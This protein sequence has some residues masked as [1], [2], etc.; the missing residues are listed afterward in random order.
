M[1]DAAVRRTA[2]DAGLMF[3]RPPLGDAQRALIDR[4]ADLARTRFAGRAA[5]YDAESAFPYEN[6]QDLHDAGLLALTIPREY[7]GLGADPVTYVHALR[8]IA[9]ACSATALTFNMHST[10]TEMLAALG[11]EAL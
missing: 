8:E 5:G 3:P 9:R 2:G 1:A 11:T 4:V 10:V 7:G 6:Y